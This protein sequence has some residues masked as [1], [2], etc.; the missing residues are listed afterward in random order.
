[1]PYFPVKTLSYNKCPAIARVDVLELNDGWQKLQLHKQLVQNHLKKLQK[2]PHFGPKL[3]E[4]L[5]IMWPKQQKELVSDTQ[6]V[7]SQLYDGF[8]NDADKTKMSVVRAAGQDQIGQ[9]DLEFSDKRLEALLPLYKARNFR[10]SLTDEDRA[11]W[12]SFRQI[13]LASGGDNS[14]LAQYFAKLNEIAQ[15]GDITDEQ[16]YI[17]EEL[18]LYGQS[19][20][21][22]P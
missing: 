1:V 20:A 21:P 4:A 6:K 16:R 5:D 18:N 7:D 2:L 11:H 9:L 14:Q 15:R 13:K 3:L 19:I 12:D 8:I 10:K 22:S 17:L